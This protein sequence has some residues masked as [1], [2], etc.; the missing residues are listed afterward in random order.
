MKSYYGLEFHIVK[1][2]L[3]TFLAVRIKEGKYG[4]DKID[5]KRPPARGRQHDKMETIIA[6]YNVIPECNISGTP[7]WLDFILRV[8]DIEENE[9]SVKESTFLAYIPGRK[10]DSMLER[11]C[12]AIRTFTVQQMLVRADARCIF[13]VK[14]DALRKE[15]EKIE[16]ELKFL[17]SNSRKDT[18]VIAKLG[19]DLARCRRHF[20]ALVNAE[21][22]DY[23]N[24]YFTEVITRDQHIHKD[25]KPRL[26]EKSFDD[27]C[28]NVQTD[29]RT[30]TLLDNLLGAKYPESTVEASAEE[31]STESDSTYEYVTD[32]ES[33]ESEDIPEVEIPTISRRR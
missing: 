33:S 31:E 23:Y 8:A 4:W 15:A 2:L 1:E 27:Y 3:N 26:H 17:N 21:K 7:T 6:I 20:A 9:R 5:V 22:S 12:R 28:Y 19:D 14:K 29:R 13:N 25:G 24:T 11:T 10:N 32:S 16:S 18:T 30:P